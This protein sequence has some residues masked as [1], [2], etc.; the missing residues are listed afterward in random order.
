MSDDLSFK[1]TLTED[2]LVRTLL[3]HERNRL[4]RWVLW[5]ILGA[6]ALSAI[7]WAVD[8]IKES[9]ANAA[10]IIPL[11]FVTIGPA[12]L[13]WWNWWMYPR[14]VARNS[15]GLGIEIEGT[16]SVDGIASRSALGKHETAWAGYA[17][18]LEST[19]HFLLYLG[20][21]VF[22]PFPKRAFADP[23]DV[24]RLRDLIRAHVPKAKLLDRPKK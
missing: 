17:G 19:N 22:N 3:A 7:I 24:D 1:Y 18:T 4:G 9:G 6:L 10:I 16:V 20:R 2:D 15:P 5:A 11:I 8:S 21:H 12:T 23:Q 14:L 13:A